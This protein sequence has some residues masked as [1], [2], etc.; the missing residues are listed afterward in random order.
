MARFGFLGGRGSGL[1]IFGRLDEL[2]V[3][4]LGAGEMSENTARHL[5]TSGVKRFFRRQ[6]HARERPNPGPPPEGTG[7]DPPKGLEILR[8]A[9]IV[10][11]S[12][13]GQRPLLKAGAVRDAMR[14]RRGKPLFLID[15]GVPRNIEPESGRIESVYLFNIDDLSRAAQVNLGERAKAV[16]CAEIILEEELQGLRTW[17]K[18]RS[19]VPAIQSLRQQVETIRL[20]EWEDYLRKNPGLDGKALARMER[21]TKSLTAKFSTPP[22]SSLKERGGEIRLVGYAEAVRGLFVLDSKRKNGSAS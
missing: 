13:G 4:I 17:L 3:L 9:D 21:L 8:E 10:I 12:I 20:R 22:R 15:I 1:K 18:H 19:L 11:S 7:L 6:P 5:V 16:A 14:D 2:T